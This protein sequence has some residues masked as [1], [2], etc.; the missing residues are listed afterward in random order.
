[1][2][3]TDDISDDLIH[4]T[5]QL[6]KLKAVEH[7]LNF[8]A[9]TW[10]NK[11]ESFAVGLHTKEI[12]KSIDL[13]IDKFRQD[14]S[15]FLVITVPPR[16]GKSQIVSRTLPAHFLGLFPDCKVIL[17][18]HTADL[19]EGFSEESRDLIKTETYQELFSTVTVDQDNSSKSHWKIAG[20]EGECY[21]CGISGSVTGQGGNL[22]ILDD[23]FRG[24]A[25]A[26]SDAARNKIWSA[27]TDDLM[28]RR[29]PVSIV[30]ILATRW[31]VDDIIGRIEKKMKEDSAF[32]RFEIKSYPAFSDDYEEGILFPERFSKTWYTEQKATLGEYASAALLQNSPT[33]RGGNMFNV[34]AVVRTKLED[35]PDIQY[36]RIWDLAHTAKERNKPDPDFTSGTKLGMRTKPGTREWELWIKDVKRMQLKAPERDNQIRHISEADGVYVKIGVEDSID[37]KD[38]LATMRTVFNGRRTVLSARG[39]GDK[40]VRASV[41]EPIFEAGNVHIPVEAPWISDWI[42]EISAFPNGAHDDQV[43][44]LSAGYALCAKK[45]GVTEVELMGV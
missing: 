43:D 11:S 30:I 20:R 10:Q 36:F 38:A 19:T 12:C 3:K 23:Y 14:I 41:L 42:A 1:M 40:V 15:S 44:N 4:K 16:H 22:I 32:P 18:G 45:P 9:Y 39:K 17:S 8:M 35:Y 26:E 37:A 6:R 28:T 33:V 21:S 27:F 25:E 2:N 34:D 13:A 29:A 31:H 24:R 5:K 7:H